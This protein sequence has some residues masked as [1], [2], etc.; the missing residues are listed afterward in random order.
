M[1]ENPAAGG[2]NNVCSLDGAASRRGRTIAV[3]RGDATMEITNPAKDFPIGHFAEIDF[4]GKKMVVE[5]FEGEYTDDSGAH[6]LAPYFWADP[7]DAITCEPLT[8][9]HNPVDLG[10][11]N[12]IIGAN[13]PLHSA[14]LDGI[15]TTPHGLTIA[16]A[17]RWAGKRGGG[18]ER[19]LR[20][21]ARQSIAAVALESRQRRG[22]ANHLG[23]L[24]AQDL[25]T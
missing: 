2:L 15:H 5:V 1:L 16:K 18:E 8:L 23:D 17:M 6:R 9:E 19:D 20:L 7:E 25:R 21:L 3:K 14:I 12:T 11:L 22:L 24:F 10:T 4:L 13:K